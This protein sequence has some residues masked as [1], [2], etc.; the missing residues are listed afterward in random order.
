MTPLLIFVD[1][2]FNSMINILKPNVNTLLNWY[3]QNGLKANSGKSH[4]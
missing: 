2:T 1:R 3:R 4:F